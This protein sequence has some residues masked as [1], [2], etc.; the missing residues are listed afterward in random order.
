MSLDPTDLNKRMLEK[1]VTQR[2]HQD[3]HKLTVKNY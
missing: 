1:L 2:K 3:K